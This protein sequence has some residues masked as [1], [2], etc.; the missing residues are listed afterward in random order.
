LKTLFLVKKIQLFVPCFV[1]QLFP[2]TAVNMYK[3]LRATGL[4]VDY[5]PLQT[6][7]GQPAFNSGYWQE[8]AKVAEKWLNDMELLKLPIVSASTSC[9]GF[10]KNYI[11][12]MDLKHPAYNSIVSNIY[13]FSDFLV[14]VMNCTDFGAVLN[15]KAVYHDSCAALRECGIKEAPRKLLANVK[16]F[17]LLEMPDAD[18]CCGFGG[19]FSVKYEPISAAMAEKKVQN[20]ISVGAELIVSADLSCLMQLQGYIS[21]H[22]LS[23]KTMHIADVLVNYEL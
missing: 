23:I 10:V 13:E 19:T 17:D 16:G 8:S 1:D 3:V 4:E 22:K 5:N 12:D 15:T 7:C 11:C 9:M 14:N 2:A 21:K 18:Q 20:A 6:C